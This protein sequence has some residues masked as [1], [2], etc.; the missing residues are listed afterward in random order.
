MHRKA[1]KHE[2]RRMNPSGGSEFDV[3]IIGGGASGLFCARAAALAGVRVLILEAG[4]E[5]GRKLCIAGGGRANFSNRLLGPEHYRCGSQRFCGP[6]LQ[7]FAP[8]KICTLLQ[9]WQLPFEERKH[10]Q[11][12]LRCRAS[13]LRAALERDCL[14]AGCRI[15]CHS[16]ASAVREKNGIFE[17]RTGDDGFWQARGLAIAT[18]SPARPQIGAN[19]SGYALAK[20]LGHAIITPRPA[21]TPIL[22]P[23]DWPAQAASCADLAGIS[24]PVKISLVP[25]SQKLAEDP[26]SKNGASPKRK[27]AGKT[28]LEWH[29]DLLFGHDGIS[30]PAALKASLFWEQG[31]AI[32][33]DFAP[34]ADLEAALD[35]PGKALVCG[36]ARRILPQRLADALLP[37]ELA[38]RKA[39]ELS[40]RQRQDL[41]QAIHASRLVPVALAGMERAEVC[42]GGVDTEEVSPKTMESR[43]LPRLWLMGEILDVTGLLGGYNLHW[44]WASAWLAAQGMA[45][46]FA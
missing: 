5:T 24:L 35:A 28:K 45:K 43:I 30:G 9:E 1:A 13:L 19:A 17:V 44:A 11:L 41:A 15:V 6:A 40:R 22:T 4:A 3:I 14:T 39:A 7:A 29:D 23:K 38:R 32:E 31:Q 37:P 42:S 8:D 20:S 27:K 36:I 34:G 26:A 46:T 2:N 16:P 21:L 12:F 25:E 18:G 33:I 10:G